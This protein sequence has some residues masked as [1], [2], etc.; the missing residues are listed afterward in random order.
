MSG[1]VSRGHH[2]SQSGTRSLRNLDDVNVRKL[3]NMLRWDRDTH[4]AIVWLRNN[5]DKFQQEVFE[6]PFMCLTVPNKNYANAVEACFNAAQIKVS[7]HAVACL[8]DSYTPTRLLCSKMRG[9]TMF[10]I[11]MLTTRERWDG[12]HAY[13]PG[14]GRMISNTKKHSFRHP[15]VVTRYDCLFASLTDSFLIFCFPVCS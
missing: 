5:R 3:Q 14:L 13:L 1:L 7:G 9:I 6:P 15:W 8:E 4:D 12:K 2:L 10:S 11:T